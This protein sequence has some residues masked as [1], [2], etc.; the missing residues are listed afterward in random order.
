MTSWT[1][2]FLYFVLLCSY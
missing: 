2:R 1:T